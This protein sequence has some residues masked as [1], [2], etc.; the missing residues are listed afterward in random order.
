MLFFDPRIS[1]S[2]LINCNTCHNVGLGGVDLLETSIGHSWQKG[3]RNSPTVLNAVFNVAQF[4]DGRATRASITTF[5]TASRST[6]F[7]NRDRQGAQRKAVGSQKSSIFLLNP[8]YTLQP[9]PPT[10]STPIHTLI[11]KGADQKT[12][13]SCT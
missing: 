8:L 6:S 2:W 5:T 4:W 13:P 12:K 3:P 7:R 1:S 9:N 10:P 11:T